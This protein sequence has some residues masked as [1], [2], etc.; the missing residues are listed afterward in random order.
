[1]EQICKNPKCNHFGNPVKDLSCS[2]CDKASESKKVYFNWKLISVGLFA[3]LLVGSIVWY[4]TSI[5]EKKV[6]E[7]ENRLVEKINKID[8]LETNAE[9]SKDS[10]K[11]LKD[12]IR[13]L[14]K[15]V[16][17]ARYLLSCGKEDDAR[18]L[19]A[20]IEKEARNYTTITIKPIDPALPIQKTITEEEYNRIFQ[21]N[22]TLKAEVE[23]LRKELKEKDEEIAR[24]LRDVND[25]KIQLG[26]LQ[27]KLEQEKKFNQK[28]FEEYKQQEAK[29]LEGIKKMY[30]TEN[31]SQLEA[32]RQKAEE[33]EKINK[34]TIANLEKKL[35]DGNNL[36]KKDKEN[37]EKSLEELR[38]GN[39]KIRDEKDSIKQKMGEE[40]NKREEAEKKL[41]DTFDKLTEQCTITPTAMKRGKHYVVEKD[42]I[43][44]NNLRVVI[45]YPKSLISDTPLTVNVGIVYE[46]NGKE[47]IHKDMKPVSIYRGQTATPIEFG[48]IKCKRGIKYK[49]KVTD[50]DSKVFY[51]PF[52]QEQ[53]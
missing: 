42:A 52:N 32:A 21:E 46:E 25:L 26:N 33:I 14:Q 37:Y 8:L 2:D 41:K 29:A 17:Q 47:I 38:G 15:K 20:E 44:F 45:D 5:I 19:L 50:G 13:V 34:K 49:F 40:K 51:R 22:E 6:T 3:L 35:E 11:V 39:N 23:K 36:S 1:M 43:K 27:W 12:K 53:R 30:E 9:I 4:F 18:T 31:L 28:T 24:L 48:D 10:A 7:T 16:G